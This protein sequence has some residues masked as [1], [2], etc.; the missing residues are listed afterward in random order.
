MEQETDGQAIESALP[1]AVETAEPNQPEFKE[2]GYKSDPGYAPVDLSDLPEEKQ[3]QIQ[4][5]LNYM[6][7]QVKDQNRT[8]GQYR[9]VA[10]QQAAQIN[11]L[12]NG[13]GQVV[14]HITEK[15]FEDTEA[16][17]TDQ[18]LDAQQTGNTKLFLEI[19]NKLVD[20]KVRKATAPKSPQQTQQPKQYNSASE[21]ANAS[22][23]GGSLSAE[24]TRVVDAWQNQRDA[25]GQLLRPWAHTNDIKNDKQ[26]QG[27]VREAEA[28]FNNPRFEH[29]SMDQKLAEVDRRMGLQR[30]NTMG[31]GQSVMGGN[32]TNQKKSGTI[33]LTPEQEKIAIRMNV[34][35]KKSDK[36]RT[37]ADKITAYIEQMKKVQSSRGVR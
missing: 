29:L 14:N 3:K 7:R 13:M 8:L 6:F 9:T 25:N 32:L 37:D 4:D 17:L 18:L 30:S 22:M 11:E 2:N 23:E 34:G 21:M 20:L 12:M 1:A 15:T 26:Y 36:P 33:R 24:D 19:N 27:V 28:V 10:D 35:S 31:N 5:R 16:S